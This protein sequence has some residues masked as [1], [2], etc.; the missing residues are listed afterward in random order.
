M[1]TGKK[2]FVLFIFSAF[3]AVFYA[4]RSENDIFSDKKFT[5]QKE[6]K[7][8]ALGFF[9][10]KNFN[11]ECGTF[12][13]YAP[14]QFFKLEPG[15][16]TACFNSSLKMAGFKANYYHQIYYIFINEATRKKLKSNVEQYIEEFDARQ[17]SKKGKTYKKYGEEPARIEWG[18]I[19]SMIDAYGNG[20][21]QFGYRFYDNSPYFTITVWPVK[22]LESRK[23]AGSEKSIKIQYFYTKKQAE[24]IAELLSNENLAEKLEPYFESNENSEYKKMKTQIESDEY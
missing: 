19:P 7:A 10:R 22:N 21:I 14:N 24:L 18:T 11:Y 8:K 13:Y 4:Q 23:A 6:T 12:S 5:E 1:K 2:F 3:N 17:L 20:K 9:S 15:E 16:G